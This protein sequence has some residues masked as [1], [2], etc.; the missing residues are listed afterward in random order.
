MEVWGKH[1]INSITKHSFQLPNKYITSG[2]LPTKSLDIGIWNLEAK[3]PGE[4][5]GG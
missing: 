4:S 2:K 5:H 1:P 3:M